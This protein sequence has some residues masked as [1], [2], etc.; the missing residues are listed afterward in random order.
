[1]IAF[2]DPPKKNIT[3]VLQDFYRAGIQVK[4]ITG[5]NAATTH[6]IAQQVGFTNTGSLTGDELMALD[7]AAIKTAVAKTSIFTRMFPEGKS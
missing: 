1:M 2:Y 5:D 7:N 6:S 4:I 3:H